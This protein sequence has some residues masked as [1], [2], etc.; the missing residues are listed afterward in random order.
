MRTTVTTY[1]GTWNTVWQNIV[2]SKE[3]NKLAVVYRDLSHDYMQ[4]NHWKFLQVGFHTSALYIP[5]LIEAQ[6]LHITEN[7]IWRN[8]IVPVLYILVTFDITNQLLLNQIWKA[9]Q[10]KM[11]TP[12]ISKRVLFRHNPIHLELNFIHR[13]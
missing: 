11:S 10:W 3:N 12:K 9:D 7:R 6:F 4:Y 8:G 5:N 2:P 13:G 1:K